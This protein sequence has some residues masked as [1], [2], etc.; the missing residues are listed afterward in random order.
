MADH[1]LLLYAF[2]V[3]DVQNGL[4][5]NFWLLRE[6]W[7]VVGDALRRGHKASTIFYTN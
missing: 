7:L 2:A 1:L 4:R 6:V 5:V 3:G